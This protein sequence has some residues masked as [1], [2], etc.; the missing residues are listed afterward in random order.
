MWLKLLDHKC[1]SGKG[2][3]VQYTKEDG[4][5]GRKALKAFWLTAMNEMGFS[6]GAWLV[7]DTRHW[8]ALS[9]LAS[10]YGVRAAEILDAQNGPST[11]NAIRSCTREGMEFAAEQVRRR[12]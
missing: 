9:C 1:R 6:L 3:Q 10:L 5:S 11:S 7:P 12:R 2:C 8:T 4:T